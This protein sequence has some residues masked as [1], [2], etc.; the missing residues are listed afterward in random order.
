MDVGFESME[1]NDDLPEFTL[2]EIM[3]LDS[4]FKEVGEESLNQEFCQKLATNF[5][6]SRHRT[7]KPAIQWEQV[8][9]WFQEKQELKAKATSSRFAPVEFVIPLC[10]IMTIN[11]PE[12][13]QKTKAERIAELSELV[14]E[15]KSSK[16]SAWYDVASFLN[17]RILCTGE[18][19]V[20]VR[21]AGFKNVEDE[22]VNVKTAVR[23]RSIP[24]EP[25]ECHKVKVGDLVLCYRENDDHALYGDAYVMGIQRRVH[26][27]EGCRC[28]FLVRFEYDDVQEEVSLT[29][30]C[31]RPT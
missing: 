1:M 23:E 21:F 7:G 22:W 25:S 26:G 13:S 28:I 19:E 24:L 14:F 6:C 2:A 10:A 16:D 4:F 31:A 3:E 17:Y 20:R 9:S 11:A 30:I 27:L 5:S 12:S 8:Q 29:R 18:L 15:A